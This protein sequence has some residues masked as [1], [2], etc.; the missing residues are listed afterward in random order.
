[1]LEIIADR[2]HRLIGQEVEQATDTQ[3]ARIDLVK[4]ANVVLIALA[5]A[6]LADFAANDRN[7]HQL[8]RQKCSSRPGQPGQ[9]GLRHAAP[10]PMSC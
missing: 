5:L 8:N 4:L 9:S 2:R 1:M 10:A 7:R 3:M 6:L